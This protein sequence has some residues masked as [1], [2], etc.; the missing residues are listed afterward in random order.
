MDDMEKVNVSKNILKK[1]IKEEKSTYDIA[2]ELQ[3]SQSTILRK[4]KKYNIFINSK[5]RKYKIISKKLIEYY[6]NHP[7]RSGTYK[8]GKR[9]KFFHN[10]CIDCKKEKILKEIRWD[11]IRCK[12]H[13]NI[14][15]NPIQKKS[16]RFGNENGRWKGGVT[17][18]YILIRNL[19][20]SKIWKNKIFERDNYI[21]QS[22]KKR[23]GNLEAH[24][25]KSFSQILE[26]FL[27]FYN[28]FSSIKDKYKLLKLAIKYKPF[29]NIDNGQTLC[30]DC[31]ELTFKK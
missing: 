20:K 31:H 3:C 25:K 12:K 13:S 10:Y 7:E 26:E 11:A 9:S 15:K 8:H 4:L 23:G 28:Q 21:C 18:L 14:Y 22:C 19:K 2:K 1:Y 24:H 6:K 30:E 16:D 29:W 5:E 17:D 27:N